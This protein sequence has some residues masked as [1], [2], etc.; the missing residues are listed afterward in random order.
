EALGPYKLD[1]GDASTGFSDVAADA[2]YAAYVARAAQIGLVQGAAGRFRPN[3]AVS[4]EELAVLFQ[5]F[6]ELRG[7]VPSDAS[8]Q[9]DLDAF[10]DA[11]S[12]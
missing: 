2:W 12:I 3:E 6:A 9:G 5:R 10:A 7:M 1:T 4:R 11:G 8:E